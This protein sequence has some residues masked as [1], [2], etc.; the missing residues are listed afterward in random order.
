LRHQAVQV[1][2]AHKRAHKQA[3]PLSLLCPPPQLLL[4]LLLLLLLLLRPP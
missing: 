1:A 4:R 2:P 3:Q